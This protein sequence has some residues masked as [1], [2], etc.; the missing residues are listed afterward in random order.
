MSQKLEW[1]RSRYRLRSK[2][3]AVPSLTPLLLH[4]SHKYLNGTPAS[5]RHLP[6]QVNLNKLHTSTRTLALQ[7]V[8]L[9]THTGLPEAP[10]TIQP[11]LYPVF[12]PLRAS[13]PPCIPVWIKEWRLFHKASVERQ[14]ISYIWWISPDWDKLGSRTKRYALALSP[15]SSTL[16]TLHHPPA[17]S[18][19][20]SWGEIYTAV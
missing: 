13:L 14:S 8:E 7:R 16:S 1:W 12:L 11:Q 2:W 9:S 5:A 15:R 4:K 18:P 20:P 3:L 19:P 6:S 10:S 17:S